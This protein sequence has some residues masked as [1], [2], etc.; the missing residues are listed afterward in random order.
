MKNADCVLILTD[1][2]NYDYNFILKNSRFIV[3]TRNAIKTTAK[4]K[5]VKIGVS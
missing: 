5:V 4:K 2:S 3:D 1:H